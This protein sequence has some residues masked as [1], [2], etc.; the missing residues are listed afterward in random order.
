MTLIKYIGRRILQMIP[1]LFGVLT[2]TFILSRFIP[3]DPV[4]AYLPLNHTT[5][6]YLEMEEYLGLNDP[7]I[8]QYF[9]YM[10]DVFTGDWGLSSKIGKKIPV[11]TIIWDRLP[12]TIDLSFFS[13][14]IASYLGIK[15]GKISAVNRNK[16]KDTL[17][18]GFALIG[19]SMPVFWL[20]MIL[21]YIFSTELGLLPGTNYFGAIGH[22]PTITGFRLIDSLLSGKIYLAIDYL[23]HLALPVACL[24]IITVASIVRQTRSSMLEVLQ[25]DYV[26]TARAKGCKEKDVI[27][28]HAL[29]NALI[30]TVTV[31][32]LSFGSLLSGAV[33]TETTF[34]LHGIGE[35]VIDAINLFDYYVLNAVIFFIAFVFIAINLIT[36]LLYGFIDPRIK[37]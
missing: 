3:G 4:I 15:I 17:S 29:K 35:L 5:Q 37:Y 25:Q 12:R 7:I 33:L 18:R 11:W 22:P 9:N 14:L 27:N 6:Q 24:S 26:R 10:I 1:V 19:V 30:P 36:D 31:I 34:N 28:S 21:R 23:Q 16:W 8:V 13:I 32:G 20:G 2:L